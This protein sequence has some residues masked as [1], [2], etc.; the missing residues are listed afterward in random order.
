MPPEQNSNISGPPQQAEKILIN[1]NISKLKVNI[2]K[3]KF[4][5]MCI[6]NISRMQQ[7]QNLSTSSRTF[8]YLSSSP[9][10]NAYT[11][12]LHTPT[13]REAGIASPQ[14]M[15]EAPAGNYFTQSPAATEVGMASSPWPEEEAPTGFPGG[16][17]AVQQWS[18]QQ[19]A[20]QS[21]PPQPPGSKTNVGE[22]HTDVK[23]R[24]HEHFT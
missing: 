12:L 22:I 13:A 19:S 24:S 10:H 20:S 7:F 2:S 5:D 18:H 9:F 21:R 4:K 23:T 14:T 1:M 15:E 6:S 16:L 17:H 11:T 8:A 3:S